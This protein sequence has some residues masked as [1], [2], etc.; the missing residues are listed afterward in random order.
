MILTTLIS[1]IIVFAL[2]IFFHELGHFTVAKLVGIKVHEFAIGMGPQLLKHKKG[3]TMYSIRALPI[4]GY[5]MM[6]GE[7]E[8]STDEK[9]FSNKPLWARIAVVAAGAI[10]N[11][12]LG[13]IIFVVMLSYEPEIPQAVIGKLIP[14]KPAQGVGLQ[15]GDRI[16]RLNNYKVHIQEDVRYFLDKNRDNPIDVTV[17]RDNQKMTFTLV[18]ELEEKYQS[19]IMGYEALTVSKNIVNIT[20]YAYYRTVFLT[21]VIFASLGDLVT[22]KAGMNQVSG[23]VGIVQG[24]GTAAKEGLR[25]LAFLAALISINLGIFNLLPIPALDGSKIMF[26]L[27]EG[28]RKKPISPEKEGMVHFVGFAML[29]LLLVFVTFND[30]V[31]MVGQ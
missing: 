14:N 26:L 7:V 6:E 1:A 11:F 23:P 30:I 13:F 24:I 4:G 5:V 16:I 18:P 15:E 3:D 9:A 2:L 29:I 20:Q 25:N 10:M 31:R 8:S 22:G 17:L 21:K 28:V 12:F 19:Y 27:I